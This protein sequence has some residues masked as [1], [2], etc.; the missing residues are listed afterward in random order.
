MACYKPF[1]KFLVVV[2]IIIINKYLKRFKCMRYSTEYKCN[3]IVKLRP[4]LNSGVFA[5]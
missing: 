4:Y 5:L 1:K 2:V 3:L